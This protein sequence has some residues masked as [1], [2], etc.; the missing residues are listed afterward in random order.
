MYIA[1][2]I[3]HNLIIGQYKHMAVPHITS[4]NSENTYESESIADLLQIAHLLKY[5]NVR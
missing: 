2:F 5:K 3:L 1:H 4:S